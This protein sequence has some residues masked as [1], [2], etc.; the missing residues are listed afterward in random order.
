MA[1]ARGSSPSPAPSAPPPKATPKPA[2]PTPPPASAQAI[3]PD[4][5]LQQAEDNL[6]AALASSSRSSMPDLSAATAFSFEDLGA[7][8]QERPKIE[9]PIAAL[10][11]VELDLRIELGRTELLIEE[12]L[13]LREGTVVPLDKL[14]GD[15]VDILVNGR[16]IARGEVLVLNDNFCVRVAEILGNNG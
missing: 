7:S 11:D 12:V 13:Q 3:S 15:P 1:A 2:A 5:L 16:L 9:F 6:S 10:Q 8:R 4:Q 14:A